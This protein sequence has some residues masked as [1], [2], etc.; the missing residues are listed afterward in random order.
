MALQL[1]FALGSQEIILIF[2]ILLFLAAP[3]LILVIFFAK[4]SPA[5]GKSAGGF[6]DELKAASE[7][8]NIKN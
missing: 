3:I 4:K 6:E 1:A 8:V 5:H 2:L 7:D